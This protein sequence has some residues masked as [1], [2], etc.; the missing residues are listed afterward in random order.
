MIRFLV[1]DGKAQIFSKDTAS[2]HVE[3]ARIVGG[4]M[5]STVRGEKYFGL[6]V[7]DALS[8]FEAEIFKGSSDSVVVRSID[9]RK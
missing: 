5:G 9:S 6:V 8:I 1:K 3:D 7:V 2:F 4:I